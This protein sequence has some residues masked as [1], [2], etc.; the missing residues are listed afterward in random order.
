MALK[1]PS[2]N[3]VRE[4]AGRFGFQMGERDL[5]EF[6][7]MV[8]GTLAM[9]RPL[10]SLPDNRPELR[11]PRTPGRFPS[12]EEDPLHAWYVKTSITGA[13]EGKL[14]GRQ[15]VIKD[16]ICLAGVPMMDGASSLEGYVPDVDAT[17]VTRILDAGGEIVGKANCEYF[18]YS[19]GSNTNSTGPTLNPFKP[20]HTSGGSSS[21]CAAI[22]G[23]G[24][25]NMA[26]GGDQGGS[27][28]TPAAFSGVYGLKATHGLVPYTGIFP[29]D[30]TV[31]HVGPMTATVADNAL[32]LEV[33]AG[34][35]ELDPRQYAPLVAPYTASLDLGVERLR[36]GVLVEGFGQAASEPDVDSKVRAAA[37]R[38][39]RLGATVKEVSLPG[40]NLGVTVWAPVIVEGALELMFKGDA[41][42]TGWRGLYVSS[43]GKAHAAWRAHVN[44]FPDLLKLGMLM[45]E[46]VVRNYGRRYYAKSQNL[47]RKLREEY[48]RALKDVDLLLMPTNPMKAPPLPGPDATKAESM[49][50]GFDSVTNTAPFNITG[51]PAMSVPCGISDGLPVGMQLVGR[52]YDECTIYRAAA[53]FERDA[54]WKTL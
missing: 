29:T 42:G 6:R 21:G 41:L 47:S 10:D 9:Y 48:D 33:L 8:A 31:D 38:F 50:P 19:A 43:L 4:L 23:S 30:H 36:I 18:C 34:Q 22:V 2:L 16:T 39:D 14:T 26:L 28:R 3:Q 12:P 53:A 7:D 37:S 15:V 25:V 1:E 44:S 35:D 32:L 17:V 20:T 11:Y 49:Y 27:I 5:L 40:H 46:F 54:D 45:G 13:P 24:E 51:H 52:W